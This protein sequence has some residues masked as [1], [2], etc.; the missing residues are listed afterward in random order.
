[1]PHLPPASTNFLY[2]AIV[3]SA[4]NRPLALR[5]LL[6]SLARAD[7]PTAH[8]PLVV[9]IDSGPD[10]ANPHVVAL[11]RDFA[12]PHGPKEVI[13][14]PQHLGLVQHF[15]WCGALTEKYG[16]MIL[17]ED[18]LVVSSV[19]YHYAASALNY[20]NAAPHIGG[21][22]LFAL[23]YNG[24][25]HHPFVPLA[26]DAA[27]FFLQIPYT[28][29]QAWTAAQWARL[30]QWRADNAARLHPGPADA[31]HALWYGFDA[32]DYFP[33]MTK[34]LVD[35][36][37]FYV[38][39]RTSHC[40]GF[41]D[42]GTHFAQATSYFQ[43]PLQ[44]EQTQYQFKALTDSDCVYDSFFEILPDR[45]KRL[46][47]DLRGYDFAVDLHATKEARHLTAPYVLTTRPMRRAE[48][49]FGLQRWP[50]EA[51]IIDN[52]PGTEITLG[53]AA[54]VRRGRCPDVLAHQQAHSYF[55]R[56]RRLSGRVFAQLLLAQWI[57]KWVNRL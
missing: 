31:L 37:Q 41:G 9:T 29:G 56:G 17:L 43:V 34:Y 50:M 30:A 53:R 8:I 19:F 24:Y 15:F 2:P 23:W 28:L 57:K 21:V 3:V 47:P 1:M 14:Q 13:H 35:T 27:V 45:L 49:T 6:T 16:A 39:P 18:D 46:A 26:D 32:G 54:D 36:G 55:T 12:W 48:R 38:Y 44:R 20:F 33:T 52:M 10:V 22:S 4:Y 42:V 5:R 51:N 40:T 11:A 7:Y 25:T